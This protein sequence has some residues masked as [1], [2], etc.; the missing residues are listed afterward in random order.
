MQYILYPN[1][2]R[3]EKDLGW[4]QSKFSFLPQPGAKKLWVAARFQR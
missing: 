1:A 2:E 4:L 3:G